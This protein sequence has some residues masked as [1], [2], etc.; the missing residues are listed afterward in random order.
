MCKLYGRNLNLF[1]PGSSV[2]NRFA[3]E[4]ELEAVDGGSNGCVPISIWLLLIDEDGKLVAVRI[5]DNVISFE[6]SPRYEKSKMASEQ[7]SFE[8][9]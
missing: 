1:P 7:L 5:G 8:S 4:V 2:D 3:S 9:E 6:S